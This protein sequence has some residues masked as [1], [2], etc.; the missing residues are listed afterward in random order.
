MMKKFKWVIVASVILLAIVTFVAIMIFQRQ[1]QEQNVFMEMIIFPGGVCVNNAHVYRFVVRNDGTF[2][3]YYGI[4]RNHCDFSRNI[5]RFFWRR[6]RITLDEQDFHIISE[7]T[8]LV[9]ENYNN[10]EESLFWGQRRVTLLFNGEIFGDSTA[11]GE[12]LQALTD[13]V[14]RLSPLTVR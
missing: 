7:L 2:I 4:S 14:V 1:R 8:S 5:V 6:A 9:A 10:M 11:L 3:S 12:S 13:E